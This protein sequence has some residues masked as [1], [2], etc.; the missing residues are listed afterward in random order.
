MNVNVFHVQL[1]FLQ[2]PWANLCRLRPPLD[3]LGDRLRREMRH[4]R[5][6]NRTPVDLP[7]VTIDMV[8]ACHDCPERN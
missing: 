4:G 3:R 2:C 7:G 6:A 1:V 8:T 5:D